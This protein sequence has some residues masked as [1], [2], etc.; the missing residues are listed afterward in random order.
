MA[1]K[2]NK[3]QYRGLSVDQSKIRPKL[4]AETRK[5]MTADEKKAY[6]AERLKEY[7]HH[8]NYMYARATYMDERD[9]IKEE[10]EIAYKFY[11]E[12]MATQSLLEVS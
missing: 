9:R 6:N 5:G 12:H 1:T 2:R 4:T 7:R 11:K 3:E 8:Y 10:K